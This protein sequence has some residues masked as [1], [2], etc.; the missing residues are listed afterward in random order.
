MILVPIEKPVVEK[1]STCYLDINKLLEHYQEEIGTGVIHFKSFSEEAAIFF[2]RDSL[3][4]G[5]MESQK[6]NL[7]GDQVLPRLIEKAASSEQAVSIYQVDSG[8]LNFYANILQA[9]VV[10][11]DLSTDFTDL[12]GLVKKL[13]NEQLSGY[14][15]IYLNNGDESGCIILEK[16]KMIDSYYFWKKGNKTK[17]SPQCCDD[18]V[19]RSREL[20][21]VFN[22]HKIPLKS[23]GGAEEVAV[24]KEKYDLD[25]DVLPMLEE[26]LIILENTIASNS[27]IKSDF[28][29][30][31]KG[32]FIEKAD[33]Y[34]FLDPFDDG[35]KYN[36]HKITLKGNTNDEI[37]IKGIIES[38]EELAESLRIL[39]VLKKY[40][41]P[42]SEK[43]SRVLSLFPFIKSS[44]FI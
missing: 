28:N 9:D 23:G 20:G 3:L 4:I 22:V 18:L 5:V 24:I 10:Y 40:I 25:L 17:N 16:G 31:L 11:K 12:E 34:D 13:S 15:E 26:L 43:H 2:E 39:P 32:K 27:K 14:I 30:L 7:Q 19:R 33:Q 37:L 42:W 44:I 29:K 38:V 41:T 8:R 1:M 36:N 6:E 35:F 21:G